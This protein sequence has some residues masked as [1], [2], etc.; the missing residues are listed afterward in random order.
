MV[1][2]C[3]K[4]LS[5][6]VRFTPGEAEFLDRL[7]DHGEVVPSLLTDDTQMGARILAHPLLQR[8]ALNVQ[9]HRAKPL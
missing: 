7:L 6:L 2:V 3:R 5:G 4:K 1:A 9:H 8:K